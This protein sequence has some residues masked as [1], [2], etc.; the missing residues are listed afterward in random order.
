VNSKKQKENNEKNIKVK[1]EKKTKCQIVL[2]IEA[3]ETLI[4]KAKEQALKDIKKDVVLPGFRK[5]KAPESTVLKKYPALFEEKFEK[6][7]ADL[8]FMMAVEKEKIPKISQGSKIIFNITEKTQTSAKINFKY[9]TEPEVPKVDPK[10]FKLKTSKKIEATKKEID[11]AVRQIRFFNASWKEVD[12]PIKENDYILIDLDSL[13]AEKPLRVFSDTR[14]EVSD[15]GM[16][17]WMKNLVLGKNKNDTL[18]GISQPDTNASEEE[19]QKFEP[20][21]VL[22]TVKKI[23]EA[24]LPAIDDDLAKKVGAKNVEDMYDLIKKMLTDNKLKQHNAEN[25]KKVYEFLLKTYDFEL[26]DSLI[27]NEITYRKDSAFKNPDFKKKFNKMNKD[28]KDQFEEALLKQSIDSIKIFYLSKQIVADNDIKI[29]NEEITQRA[30]DI[31][32]RETGQKPDF[33]NIPRNIYALALSQ[34]VL[35]KAEDYILDQ[36][37]KT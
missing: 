27:Q 17:I 18:E 21:K 9:E 34:L 22:V 14:F 10:G 33:K 4:K 23:E 8:S 20:K 19:R 3:D 24:I 1:V 15:K 36:A 16:A 2:D 28:Q 29:T 12:R 32:Y 31:I 35:T 25:R 6:K 11:E 5:G 26:P 7:L 37:S 30:F 13:E